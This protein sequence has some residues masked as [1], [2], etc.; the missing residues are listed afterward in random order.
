[1]SCWTR[2]R[3]S[4]GPCRVCR[5]QDPPSGVQWWGSGDPVRDMAARSNRPPAESK[6]TSNIAAAANSLTPLWVKAG[7]LLTRVQLNTVQVGHSWLS[8]P[9][10]LTPLGL[11]PNLQPARTPWARPVR[12]ANL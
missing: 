2:L 7:C 5:A 8:Q 6:I 10:T 12:A 3:S 1:M 4:S 11:K 9:W